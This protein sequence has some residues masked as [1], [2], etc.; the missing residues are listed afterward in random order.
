MVDGHMGTLYDSDGDGKAD[1]ID[2]DGDGISDGEDINGDGI[3]TI[4]S[5]L[6]GSDDS[7][8]PDDLK[9]IFAATPAAVENKFAAM[10]PL[11]GES[12]NGPTVGASGGVNL[13]GGMVPTGAPMPG[14]LKARQ[15]GGV[16]SCAAFATAGAVALV[17]YNSE[18]TTNPAVDVNTLWPSPLYVYQYNATF[19]ATKGCSGTNIGKNLGRFLLFGAPA[20]SELVYTPNAPPP[21]WP[22]GTDS[23]LCTTP[24]ADA[25]EGSPQREAF[26]IG[27]YVAVNGSGEAFR[28]EVKR[29]LD[30]GRPVVFGVT[31]PVGF[32]QFRTTVLDADG[33][34]T[35]VTKPFVGGGKCVDPPPPEPGHCGGHAMVFVGYDDERSAYRV[36]NS[37]GDDWGDNGY[38]W[39]NYAAIET[40]GPYGSAVIPLP[41]MTAPLAAP[42]PA[43]LAVTLETPAGLAQS[44]L[45]CNQTGWS[46]I[47]RVRWSEP[48][49]VTRV[50]ADIGGSTFALNTQQP[51]LVGDLQAII[52]G[53]FN[54]SGF[55]PA[56]VAGQ[57]ISLTL[58]VTLRDGTSATRMLGPLTIPQPTM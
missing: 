28:S 10:A 12:P 45:C 6:V 48:V 21:A 43:A 27:G 30:M 36:L 44:T 35:D 49:T 24:A 18:K 37:W 7:D 5:D 55:D 23:T 3:I 58:S 42:D 9:K 40:L 13:V 25:A 51:Q 47:V 16:G 19:D 2:I 15:Q 54:N 4:W 14:V 39:W 17:R 8:T 52:P 22:K 1:E 46:L 29:Q 20:D 32:G 38:V 11:P 31:L 34:P 50:L 56:T 53:S 26:R 33:Q 57:M 41:P